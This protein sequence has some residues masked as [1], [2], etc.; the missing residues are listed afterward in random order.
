MPTGVGGYAW[1][2][3]LMHGRDGTLHGQDGMMHGPAGV[4]HGHGQNHGTGFVHGRGGDAREIC[5]TGEDRCTLD[6]SPP[7]P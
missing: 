2:C 5:P 6:L 7:L 1:F 3:A 4:M